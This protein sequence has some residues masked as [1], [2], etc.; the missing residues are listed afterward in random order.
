MLESCTRWIG[1][2][3]DDGRKH[4]RLGY[5]AAKPQSLSNALRTTRS[6]LDN[7]AGDAALLCLAQNRNSQEHK[8]GLAGKPG[9]CFASVTAPKTMN[10]II[11][12]GQEHRAGQAAF[13]RVEDNAFHLIFAR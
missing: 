7:V 6:T 13:Q 8:G 2:S 5:A 1:F 12:E 4:R 10:I 9:R 3:E 11:A